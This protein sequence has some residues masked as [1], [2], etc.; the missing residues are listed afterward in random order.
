MSDDDTGWSNLSNRKSVEGNGSLL[1]YACSHIFGDV[2]VDNIYCYLL[3]K[4]ESEKAFIDSPLPSTY[5]SR[6]ASG[7]W[8]QDL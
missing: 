1:V 6:P 4:R 2:P 5:S 8:N 3:T 7:I